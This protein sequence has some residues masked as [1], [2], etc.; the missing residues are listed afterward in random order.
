MISDL[1]F[2]PSI[3]GSDAG[4]HETWSRVKVEVKKLVIDSTGFILAGHSLGGAVAQIGAAELAVDCVSF[5]APKPW[6]SLNFGHRPKTHLRVV[7]HGDP[8]PTLPPFPL[9]K[10]WS[11]ETFWLGDDD[12]DY[13]IKNHSILTYI[14][15]LSE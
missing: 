15:N 12:S 14:Q 9:Y 10:T 3:N 8:V 4:F 1:K 5:G 2:W 11:T 6:F 13:S 7:D